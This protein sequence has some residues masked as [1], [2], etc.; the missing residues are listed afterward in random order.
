MNPIERI[1]YLTLPNQ[2]KLILD[3]VPYT[4]TISIGI[5]AGAGSYTENSSITGFSHFL[6]HM[7]FKGTQNR[8][9]IQINKDIEKYGG[10]LNAFTDKRYTCFYVKILSEY[11]KEAFDVLSDL[12]L[13]PIF[14]EKE[15]EK[16]KKVVL[17]EIS[18][19]EDNPDD[20]I[21]ELFFEHVYPK[22]FMGWPVLGTREIIAQITREQIIKYWQNFYN[23]DNLI[24]SVCGN[25]DREQIINL[26]SPLELKRK[27][28]TIHNPK[29]EF[30][31]GTAFKEKEVEQAHLAI[32]LETFPIYHDKKFALNLLNNI[33]GSNT[34]SRLYINIREKL[35]LCYSISTSVNLDE[36]TGLLSVFTSS[37]VNQL[38]K[39]I[40]LVIKELQNLRKKPPTAEEIKIGKAQ[41]KSGI[42]FNQESVSYRMQKNANNIFWYGK[43]IYYQ[44]L[45][46]QI[47]KISKDDLQSVFEHLLEKKALSA[48]AIIP[49]G[50]KKII[51]QK[52]CLS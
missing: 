1:E 8:N 52:I 5:L 29:P 35:G 2:I 25:F 33:L 44:E 40:D 30:F 45:I 17:E 47:E 13:N 4:N 34:S 50:T 42:L 26:L 28:K 32:G 11:F 37:Q 7:V 20:S 51:P 19:Y 39:I 10:Y 38:P 3:P 46:N 48:F 6:E 27:T 24:I 21:L 18:M 41:M 31:Y 43:P 12:V 14:P 15:L 22:S 36:K 49:H 23:L 16:E 9:Y